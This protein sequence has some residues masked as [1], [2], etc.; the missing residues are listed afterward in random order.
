MQ[1]LDPAFTYQWTKGKPV[2]SGPK[3]GGAGRGSSD[4]RSGCALRV[5]RKCDEP[6]APEVWAV[7]I[8]QLGGTSVPQEPQFPSPQTR[9]LPTVFRALRHSE[10]FQNQRLRQWFSTGVILALGDMG[11]VWSHFGL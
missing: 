6:Q 9:V 5:P 10:R 7:V 4:G 8:K 11:K 1:T 2:A 3:E